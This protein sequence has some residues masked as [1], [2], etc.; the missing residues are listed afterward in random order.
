MV[1][2][3]GGTSSKIQPSEHASGHSSDNTGELRV[4]RITADMDS[5]DGILASTKFDAGLTVGSVGNEVAVSLTDVLDNSEHHDAGVDV[6]PGLVIFN[7][8]SDGRLVIK[9]SD[10]TN[11][12]AEVDI[13][14]HA[15]HNDGS[16]ELEGKEGVV[17]SGDVQFDDQVNAHGDII[18]RVE[19]N[20]GT[21]AFKMVSGGNTQLSMTKVAVDGTPKANV[22]IS[23]FTPTEQAPANGGT[24]KV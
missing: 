19:D 4:G 23:N 12:A 14:I 13:H 18:I 3:A 21:P 24:L 15:S 9:S 20:D 2:G 7:D 17:F 8:G 16:I 10:N 5:G 11:A 22:V 6:K 1:T